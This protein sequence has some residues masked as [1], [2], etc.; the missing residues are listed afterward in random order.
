MPTLYKV[1]NGKSLEVND[2]M[3]VIHGVKP[4]KGLTDIAPIK[5]EVKKLKKKD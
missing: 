5:K 2:H 3:I 4:I 1:L